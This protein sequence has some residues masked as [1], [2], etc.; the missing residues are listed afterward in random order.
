[1]GCK[2]CA[3]VNTATSRTVLQKQLI[4]N[5]G[6]LCVCGLRFDG[7]AASDSEDGDSMFVRDVGVHLQD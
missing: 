1:M 6:V 5:G 7:H 2:G 4:C 3:C